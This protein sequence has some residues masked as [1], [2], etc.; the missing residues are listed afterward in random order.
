M[1]DGLLSQRD[2]S[3]AALL[4]FKRETTDKLLNKVILKTLMSVQLQ[5]QV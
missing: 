5:I 2:S 3:S 4:A 1:A